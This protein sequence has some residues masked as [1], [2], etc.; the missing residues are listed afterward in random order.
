MSVFTF[1]VF[2][3]RFIIRFLT[4]NTV[5]FKTYFPSYSSLGC[6]PE[7][8]LTHYNYCSRI[9][10]SSLS[11]LLLLPLKSISIIIVSIFVVNCFTEVTIS[12]W[13]VF[14]QSQN[15]WVNIWKHGVCFE[16]SSLFCLSLFSSSDIS[17]SK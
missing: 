13:T 11:R 3:L 15:N 17:V 5:V 14:V 10:I 7:I 9:G 12:L 1:L 8:S 16:Y 6:L 2:R 4:I